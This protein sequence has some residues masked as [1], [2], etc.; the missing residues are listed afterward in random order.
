MERV[1]NNLEIKIER[2]IPASPEAAYDAWLNPKVPGT[3]W[4]AASKLILDCRMDG[5]FYARM[6]ETP[7]YGLF[8]VLK[9]GQEVQHTWMSPYTE[10]QES[11]VTVTFTR[12]GNDTLMKLAHTGLP[13][14]AK[15]LAHQEGWTFFL[16]TF[17]KQFSEARRA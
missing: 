9:H 12:I 10:G 13:N 15:G 7:H 17:P 5:L 3:P 4:S 6:N 16:D 2:K 8:T 11:L 14:N 1:E